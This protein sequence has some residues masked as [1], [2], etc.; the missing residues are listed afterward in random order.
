MHKKFWKFKYILKKILE[1]LEKVNF[2]WTKILENLY[3]YIFKS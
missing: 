3:T 2:L 1:L